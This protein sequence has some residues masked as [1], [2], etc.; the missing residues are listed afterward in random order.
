[1]GLLQAKAQEVHGDASRW[2]ELVSEMPLGRAATVEEVADVVVF[3]ASDR[4]GYVSGVVLNVDGGHGARG[5]S[6][7]Q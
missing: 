6:F 1:M 4:A 7:S 5:G 3:L 2:E